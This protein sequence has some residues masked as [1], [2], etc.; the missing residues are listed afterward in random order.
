MSIDKLQ[1]QLL[2]AEETD[3]TSRITEVFLRDSLSYIQSILDSLRT[4]IL[5]LDSNLRVKTAS[6]G[7]YQTFNVSPDTAENSFLYDLENGAWNISALR[8][9]LEE[10]LPLQKS[11][12]DFEIVHDFP[13]LG[14][15]VMLLSGRTLWRTSNNTMMILLVIEDITV[16]KKIEEELLR[17]NEDLQRFAYMAAHD[18]RT[19]LSAAL[20]L[21]QIL[22]SR[23]HERLDARE[24][25]ML[26]TA[27]E[28]MKRL[29]TLMNDI[30]SYSVAKAGAQ[31]HKPISLKE[32]LDIAL[33]NLSADITRNGAVI[34]HGN[35]PVIEAD[36]TQLVL[37]FQ[38]LLGNAI[39]YRRADVAPIIT[40]IAEQ[41]N[42]EWVISIADNG[43]GFEP[44]EAEKIFEPF[45]RL[46]LTDANGSGIG[47]ATCK[48][49]VEGR[50]GKIW[51]ESVKNRGS[52]FLFTVPSVN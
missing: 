23:I 39:K 48:R 51:A 49:I 15:L 45:T 10:V 37:L 22:S 4:P 14:R 31:T 17:S 1:K 21:S 2:A 38:N 27:I 13:G 20:V 25:E 8:Q 44:E 32:P 12:D 26:S 46:Q 52:V 41:K 40:I 3:R 34:H 30:L 6:R 5:I 43:Q 24:N 36:C 47:L 18:L 33:A 16:R 11:F 19:P 7:F 50:R 35:L 9:Q 42:S 29:G 28:S